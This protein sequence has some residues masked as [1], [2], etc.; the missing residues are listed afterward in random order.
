[1]A[2]LPSEPQDASEPASRKYWR[3]VGTLTYV[4]QEAEYQNLSGS[5]VQKAPGTLCKAKKRQRCNSS[6]R[7]V[8]GADGCRGTAWALDSGQ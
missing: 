2:C 7:E 4:Q 8:V 1:M 5:T 3:G 6:W